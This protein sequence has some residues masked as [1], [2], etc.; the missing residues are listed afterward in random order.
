MR[1]RMH[2]GLAVGTAAIAILAGAGSPAGAATTFRQLSPQQLAHVVVSAVHL[3][4]YPYD[5][6]LMTG[7]SDRA[8]TDCAK[9]PKAL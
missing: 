5:T 7:T 8:Q 2:Q 9:L 3:A 1:R 6:K 4:G